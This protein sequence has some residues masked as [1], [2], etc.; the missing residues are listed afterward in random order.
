[1]G[2]DE[3]LKYVVSMGVL[4]P[5]ARELAAGDPIVVPAPQVEPGGP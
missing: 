1:M 5:P 3:A 4:A 2:V